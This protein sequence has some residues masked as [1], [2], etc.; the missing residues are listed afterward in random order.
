MIFYS[1][2]SNLLF[3]SFRDTKFY[4]LYPENY[5]LIFNINGIIN[6]PKA[7]FV[8]DTVIKEKKPYSLR[9]TEGVPPWRT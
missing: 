1:N 7:L 6:L 3:F 9:L 5:L 8:K 4:L 2:C